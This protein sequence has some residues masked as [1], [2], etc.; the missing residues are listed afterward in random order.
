MAGNNV[1]SGTAKN[2]KGIL[3]LY[4]TGKGCTTVQTGNNTASDITLTLPD[5]TGTIPVVSLSGT[6]LTITT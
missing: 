3:K 4:G 5:T 1:A 6:T 2:A